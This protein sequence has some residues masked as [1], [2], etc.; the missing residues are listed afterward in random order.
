MSPAPAPAQLQSSHTSSPH[1]AHTRDS[2]AALQPPYSFLR[3]TLHLEWIAE[4]I[5]AAPLSR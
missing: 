3:H 5:Q 2:S 4:N 1:A